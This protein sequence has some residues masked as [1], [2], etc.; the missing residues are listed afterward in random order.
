MLL[1]SQLQCKDIK[2]NVKKQIKFNYFLKNFCNVYF[3]SL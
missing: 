2:K 1:K 3:P